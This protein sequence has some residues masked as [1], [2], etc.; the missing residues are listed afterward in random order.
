MNE[1]VFHRQRLMN[2]QLTFFVNR[3]RRAATL[4]LPQVPYI[5]AH[6]A[7]LASPRER[8]GK[9]I[10]HIFQLTCPLKPEVRNKT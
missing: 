1:V 2:I 8:L 3:G 9:I 4:Q 5:G 6:L 10:A 7:L